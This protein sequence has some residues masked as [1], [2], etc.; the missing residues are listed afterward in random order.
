MTHAINYNICSKIQGKGK[1]SMP[2]LNILSW[3]LV[4]KRLSNNASGVKVGKKLRPD[5]HHVSKI[6]S[7]K[8]N[9]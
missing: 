1:N 3:T 2:K 4:K 8:C 6:K 9:S 5:M 7:F